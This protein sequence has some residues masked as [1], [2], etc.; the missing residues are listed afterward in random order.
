MTQAICTRV[1]S[2]SIGPLLNRLQVETN[3]MWRTGRH[4]IEGPYG[5]DIGRIDLL[6]FDPLPHPDYGNRCGLCCSGVRYREKYKLVTPN[7]FV[8]QVAL[9]TALDMKIE[10]K[11]II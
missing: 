7:E 11:F 10:M 5:V 3:A 1:N 6:A 8:R 4:L 9:A 2:A